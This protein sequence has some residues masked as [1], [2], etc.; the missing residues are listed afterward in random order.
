LIDFGVKVSKK[1][2][3]NSEKNLYFSLK[4]YNNE[5]KNKRIKKKLIKLNK[6]IQINKP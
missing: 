5:K 2:V 4:K 6:K 3:K 1:F